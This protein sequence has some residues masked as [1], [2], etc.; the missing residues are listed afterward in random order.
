MNR[1][2][3]SPTPTLSGVYTLAEV[4][5]VCK[6]AAGIELGIRFTF[7]LIALSCIL[8]ENYNK[9]SCDHGNYHLVMI[10]YTLPC[11]V[12]FMMVILIKMYPI[13]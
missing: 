8:E 7:F 6:Y 12:M 10:S 3:H 1:K 9:K 11:H 2:S 4:A 5:L 13:E